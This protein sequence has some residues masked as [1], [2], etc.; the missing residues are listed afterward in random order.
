YDE[1]P[2]WP[3]RHN[4]NPLVA[5]RIPRSPIVRG[6][7]ERCCS[8]DDQAGATTTV[9]HSLG[10]TFSW[11][12]RPSRRPNKLGRSTPFPIQQ[13]LCTLAPW[14]EWAVEASPAWRG[15]KPHG[16]PRASHTRR[17][18]PANFFASSRICRGTFFHIADTFP[19]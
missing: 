17:L 12:C 6:T 10:T 19:A 11:R 13:S 16:R 3:V 18:G 14:P 7:D 8:V 4:A 1:L 5:L 2:S 15:S 9:G